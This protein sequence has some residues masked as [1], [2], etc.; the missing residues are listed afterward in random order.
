MLKDLGIL[1][2]WSDNFEGSLLPQDRAPQKIN[3]WFEVLAKYELLS[4]HQPLVRPQGNSIPCI[5][6]SAF[7][8]ALIFHT[9]S[10]PIKFWHLHKLSLFNVYSWMNKKQDWLRRLRFADFQYRR[11]AIRKLSDN[12]YFSNVVNISN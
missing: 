2:E 10:S 1:I 8:I 7:T 4:R 6:N 5:D 11:Q 12:Y 3:L 9:I